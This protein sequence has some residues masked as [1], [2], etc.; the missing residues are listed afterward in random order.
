M[1]YGQ[2]A[3]WPIGLMVDRLYGWLVW[4]SIGMIGR[5]A[6][7]RCSEI[8]YS[9]R[10]DGQVKQLKNAWK[11]LKTALKMLEKPFNN[12]L[13]SPRKTLKNPLKDL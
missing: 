12:A 2:Y 11:T 5:N 13:K 4:W 6:D 7:S 3:Q 1:L 10:L 8:S 9:D